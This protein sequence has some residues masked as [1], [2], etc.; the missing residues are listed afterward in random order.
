MPYTSMKDS[1]PKIITKAVLL[2]RIRDLKKQQ[3]Q[4]FEPVTIKN[5]PRLLNL[6]RKPANED[7]YITMVTIKCTQ[8]EA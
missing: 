3:F 2:T 5:L 8:G 4:G 7:T 6:L 1:K